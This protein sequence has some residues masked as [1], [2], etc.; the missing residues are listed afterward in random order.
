[1]TKHSIEVF[2][3]YRVLL[4]TALLVVLISGVTAAT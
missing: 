2:A 1:V 3:F 4:G